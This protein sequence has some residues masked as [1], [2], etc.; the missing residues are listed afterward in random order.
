VG[1]R[2]GSGRVIQFS[3]VLGT[4]ELADPAYG[5]LVANAV[6]WSGINPKLIVSELKFEPATVR[7]GGSLVARFAGTNLAGD[8]YLDVRF[9]DPGDSSDRVAVNWQQGMS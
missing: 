9:R 8:T 4:Q 6:S 7:V 2:F 5:R 1:W 3:T